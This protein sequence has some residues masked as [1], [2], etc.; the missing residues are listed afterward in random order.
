MPNLL[1]ELTTVTIT[2]DTSPS[3]D[4]INFPASNLI[5]NLGNRSSNHLNPLNAVDS[6][7]ASYDSC[8]LVREAEISS[9]GHIFKFGLDL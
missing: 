1:Q 5:N 3:S 8:Y 6:G 7:A 4:E 2:S 9:T